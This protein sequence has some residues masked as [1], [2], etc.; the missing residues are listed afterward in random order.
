[1]AS[2]TC[3]PAGSAATSPPPEPCPHC[4]DG[5]ETFRCFGG[6]YK[7]DVDLAREIVADQRSPVELEPDD[8]AYSLKRCHIYEQHV[9]HVSTVH[10]GIIA[11][12]WYPEP[13]G[14]VAHGHML[15]D[16]H[17]RAA[18]CLRDGLPYYVHVLSEAESRQVTLVAP[19]VDAIRQQQ[20]GARVEE[21]EPVSA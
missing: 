11:H 5:S 17:H 15:I 3:E 9:D 19:D 10:P 8:V 1:M 20:S 7:F 21:L 18:R 13:D 12:Y 14:T 6:M 16:G 2:T 4:R